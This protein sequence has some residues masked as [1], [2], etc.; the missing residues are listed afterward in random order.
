[1]SSLIAN[2]SKNQICVEVSIKPCIIRTTYVPLLKLIHVCNNNYNYDN[3]FDTI[4]RYSVHNLFV[5]ANFYS[6]DSHNLRKR[7][8][9]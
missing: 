2:Q 5:S 7:N 4:I 3:L 6:L 8:L 9:S 1:M